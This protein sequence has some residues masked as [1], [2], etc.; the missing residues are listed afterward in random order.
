MQ[1]RDSASCLQLTEAGHGSNPRYVQS[2]Y[3][4]M[5]CQKWITF[6]TPHEIP[7]LFL[8]TAG[9]SKMPIIEPP[10]HIYAIT[11]S[12]FR[13]WRLVGQPQWDFVVGTLPSS[14]G[15]HPAC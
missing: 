4:G 15:R 2:S 5:D 14:C 8:R 6:I 9:V 3:K 1:E 7:R 11:G 12:W 10:V 13:A